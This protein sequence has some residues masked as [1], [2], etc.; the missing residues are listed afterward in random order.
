MHGKCKNEMTWR[1]EWIKVLCESEQ[2]ISI[3]LCDKSLPSG[4]HL[5]LFLWVLFAQM[6]SRELQM[7]KDIPRKAALGK[8]DRA[9]N[10]SGNFV[11]PFLHQR[12]RIWA[13]A[14]SAHSEW[15]RASV[16]QPTSSDCVQFC[17]CLCQ[18]LPRSEEFIITIMTAPWSREL[19]V[20]CI[21]KA[22]FL[23]RE[24]WT[25]FI[26]PNS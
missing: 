13:K 3:C 21:I 22:G 15:L 10:L 26:N 5:L 12:Q 25:K 24:A 19:I 17:R 8:R 1:R 14:A 6:I 20:M 9:K 7:I 4:S 2:N 11:F 23:S 16:G 18:E